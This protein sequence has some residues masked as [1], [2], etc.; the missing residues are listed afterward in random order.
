MSYGCVTPGVVTNTVQ[1]NMQENKWIQQLKQADTGPIIVTGAAGFI[2]FHTAQALLSL[3][4]AVV[5]VDSLSDY[6]DVTLKK[7]RIQHLES[8]FPS[9]FSFY[10]AEVQDKVRMKD[11][12]LKTQPKY[13]VHL[14]A[15]AGV[16]YS[17]ENPYSYV[18]TNV[19]GNLVLLELARHHGPLT[20]FVYASTSSVYGSN[21]KMPFSETDRTDHPMAL[22]AATKKCDELM[23]EAYNHLFSIPL[24]GL[25]FFSVYGPWG[26][27][28]MALYIFTK[29]ILKGE[30]ITVFNHGDMK[31]DFTYVDDIVSG[32][33]SALGRPVGTK[34]KPGH[35]IYNLGN[36]HQENLS[37]YI[38]LI[39]KYTGK[40]A[41]I[42]NTGMQPGDIPAS[43]SDIRRAQDELE[44]Q[45]K[46]RIETG[47]RNFVEWFKAYHNL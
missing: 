28:D 27:P 21:E 9:L 30:P 20:N 24:I 43:L 29:K 17:L 5:G 19:M 40:K 47:V 3:G 31:R 6:Y 1:V 7:N 25:R 37:D 8:Q 41:I 26:R 16:R 18:E 22:Y 12:W 14:A 11:I 2:G 38:A 15:Q 42:E 44:F 45:P 36:S 33:L 46:T 35:R 39:E 23:A 4:K 10:Q 34:G 13:L 32:I